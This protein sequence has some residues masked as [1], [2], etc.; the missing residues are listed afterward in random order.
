MLLVGL[1]NIIPRGGRHLSFPFEIGAAY[2][3]SPQINLNLSGTICTTEG[4]VNLMQN[5]EAQESLKQEIQK[6]N[7]DLSSYPLFPIVSM[8][9]ACHF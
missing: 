8:G 6:L 4:C 2:T 5:T 3:G 1:G 9:V 7:K